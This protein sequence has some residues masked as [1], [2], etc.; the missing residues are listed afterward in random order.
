MEM[1]LEKLVIELSKPYS[2][3]G[4]NNPYTA[5]LSV[6]Y[7]NNSMQVKLPTAT[8]IEILKLAGGHIADAAQVQ[9]SEFVNTAIAVSSMPLIDVKPDE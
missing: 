8:C 7:N 3:P 1:K 6:S 2:N 4:P 9:I 5:T